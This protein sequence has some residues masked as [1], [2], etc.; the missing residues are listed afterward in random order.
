MTDE[1]FNKL[2][3]VQ[4]AQVA[5]LQG[6]FNMLQIHLASQ[7]SIKSVGHHNWKEV[8]HLIQSADAITKNM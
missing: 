7:S 2:L 6:I 1:Q 4:A 8:E 3:A 5:A